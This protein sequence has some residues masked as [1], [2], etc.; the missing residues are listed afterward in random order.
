M[1]F[2]TAVILV[3]FF[4]V[5]ATAVGTW[6]FDSLTSVPRNVEEALVTLTVAALSCLIVRLVLSYRPS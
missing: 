4:I 5:S 6:A 1:T 2:R 3:L